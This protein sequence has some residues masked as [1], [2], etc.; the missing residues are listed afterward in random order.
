MDSGIWN[1]D[2][3]HQK[4]NVNNYIFTFLLPN[5]VIAFPLSIFVSINSMFEPLIL[6]MIG[7]ICGIIIL[8]ILNDISYMICIVRNRKNINYLQFNGLHLYF[9]KK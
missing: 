6:K 2:T 5:L 7:L 1:D 3:L 9:K 8:G 4:K